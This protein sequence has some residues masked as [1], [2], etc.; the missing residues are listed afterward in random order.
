MTRRVVTIE[1]TLRELVREYRLNQPLV[2]MPSFLSRL[3]MLF[4]E[5]ARR[6]QRIAEQHYE[7]PF[8]DIAGVQDSQ[9]KNGALEITILPTAKWEDVEHEVLKQLY[10]E[11]HWRSRDQIDYKIRAP[12]V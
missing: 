3:E 10:Y 4:S 6:K 9:V 1:H 7:D 8:L 2:C 5:P 12:S 11:Q